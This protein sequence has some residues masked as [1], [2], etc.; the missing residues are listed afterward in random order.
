MRASQTDVCF[1]GEADDVPKTRG[2]PLLTL[3]GSSGSA[4][5]ERLSGV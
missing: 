4:S 3:K 1:R 5:L 2:C